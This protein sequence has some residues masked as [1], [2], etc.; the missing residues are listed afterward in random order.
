MADDH[1]HVEQPYGT[2]PRDIMI[3]GTFGVQAVTATNPDGT[4]VPSVQVR[5]TGTD[6]DTG[7][8]REVCL[9]LPARSIGVLTGQMIRHANDA[10]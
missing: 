5:A 4:E 3:V 6:N 10:V 2:K 7:E 9:V 8:P 1:V